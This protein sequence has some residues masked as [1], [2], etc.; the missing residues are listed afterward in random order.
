MTAVEAAYQEAF[1]TSYSWQRDQFS[2]KGM[3]SI[4]GRGSK[5]LLNDKMVLIMGQGIAAKL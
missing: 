3:Q 1:N 2:G 5:P 4:L